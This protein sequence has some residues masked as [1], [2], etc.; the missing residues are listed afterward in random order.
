MLW[1][2]I[3][4]KYKVN[5]CWPFLLLRWPEPNPIYTTPHWE[6]L[7][8]PLQSFPESPLTHLAPRLRVFIYHL[9]QNKSRSALAAINIHCD[10]NSA[11]AAAVR[12]QL[13]TQH[14]HLPTRSVKCRPNAVTKRISSHH[15]FLFSHFSPLQIH[16][17]AS[18]LQLF[19]YCH[20]MHMY[21]KTLNN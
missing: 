7:Y 12:W 13:L 9:L 19:V 5:T 18:V 1:I 10:A 2:G 11:R 3:I 16:N 4:H 8:L 14:T 21:S 6:P 20:I 17:I 15:T